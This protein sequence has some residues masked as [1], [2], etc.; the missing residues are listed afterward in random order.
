MVWTHIVGGGV[1]GLTLAAELSKYP[2]LPG[3][4]VVSD[5][6]LFGRE[7]RTYSFW[8]DDDYSNFLPETSQYS[9]WTFSAKDK[10]VSQAG[11]NWHYYRIS[12][13]AY[14]EKCKRLIEKH[15]QCSLKSETLKAAPTARYVFDSRPPN[16]TRFRAFQ[17]FVGIE[18]K[19][20]HNFASDVALLMTNMRTDDTGFYFE[21]MLPINDQGLLIESTFFGAIPG[22]MKILEKNSIEWIKNNNLTGK[23]MRKEMAHI[24]MGLDPSA[25]EDWGIPIGARGQMTRAS[26]GYGFLNMR[27]WAK[28]TA[29]RLIK[30]QPIRRYQPP[31]LDSW[32]DRQL[33]EILK[34]MPEH[35]PNIFLS[36]AKNTKGDDFASFLTKTGVLNALKIILSA[37]P[38]PF[39]TSLFR[40]LRKK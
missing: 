36:M 20:N 6:N 11:K 30:G 32:M 3:T 13:S 16:M 29:R 22:N 39:L 34:T 9:R 35:L 26:S 27:V 1:A 23:I 12:G 15:P 10:S 25:E 7:E 17:S 19:C 8:S 37:P 18:I 21:Y 24:P 38:R 31:L 2:T 33:L 5:P 14:F 28:R 4:V 40:N